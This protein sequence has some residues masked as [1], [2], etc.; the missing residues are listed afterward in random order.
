MRTRTKSGDEKETNEKGDVTKRKLH[1]EVF[2]LLAFRLKAF[3]DD[4]APERAILFV[5]ADDFASQRNNPPA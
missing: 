2:L 4:F 1:T 3:A 5:V